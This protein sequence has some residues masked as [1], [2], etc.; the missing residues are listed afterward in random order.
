MRFA[1][2]KN[3]VEARSMLVAYWHWAN[4][5]SGCRESHGRMGK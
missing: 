4:R 3:F 1:Y 2:H 5:Y